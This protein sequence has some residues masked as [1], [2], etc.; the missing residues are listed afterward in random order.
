M[1]ISMT[2]FQESSKQM[3]FATLAEWWLSKSKY[4][5][6]ILRM[7]PKLASASLEVYTSALKELLPTPTRS[8][9]T[10]NLRDLSNVFQGMCLAGSTLQSVD[11]LVRLWAHESLRVF[12]DRLIDDGDR[13]WFALKLSQ[14]AEAHFSIKWCALTCIWAHSHVMCPGWITANIERTCSLYQEIGT[15]AA[16]LLSCSCTRTDGL[17]LTCRKKVMGRL[18]NTQGDVKATELRSLL[19][20]D[21]MI[22]AAD[23]PLYIELKDPNELSR[24]VTDYLS[25]YNANTKVPMNLVLFTF[26]LEHVVRICRILR[27]PGGHALLVGLGGSGRQSLTRL[28]AFICNY[29]IMNIEL[30]STYSSNDWKDDLKAVLKAAGEKGLPTVFFFSDTQIKQE[31]MIEDLSNLLNTGE[32]PNLFD[33]SDQVT[34][35]EG[36]SAKAKKVGMDG[37]RADLFNFFI[38]QVRKYLHICLAFSP[39]GDAFRTRLRMFPALVTNT[40]INWCDA[41]PACMVVQCMMLV[42][43][44][45]RLAMNAPWTVYPWNSS[46]FC[47]P[48]SIV[49]P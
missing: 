49:A 29:Q 1:Q 24:V 45:Y 16:A 9:Y 14:A 32:V 31:A 47:N 25:E 8:H 34:I 12:A 27:Q 41:V 2:E 13:E 35:G 44:S 10:F 43:M 7:C 33:A 11:D 6:D 17:Y 23:P 22:A 46:E 28:A 15:Y 21:F 26:A 4:G 19:F 3:I 42:P 48:R 36:V 5:E 30:S 37:S 38:S 18:A 39:I 40:T 20:G